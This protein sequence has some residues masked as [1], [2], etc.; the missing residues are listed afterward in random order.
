MEVKQIVIGGNILSLKDEQAR[1]LAATLQAALDTLNGKVPTQASSSNQLADK[2]FV[3]SSIDTA[4][5]TFRGTF[6]SDTE[7][8]KASGDANDYAFLKSTDANGNISY[9]RYKYVEGSGWT[10]EYTL[11]NSSFTAAQW[12]TI[13]S[14]MT[15]ALV[16]KLNGIEAGAQKNAA[17]TVVDASYVHTDN[18]YTSTEKTKLANIEA[19]A[20]KNDPNTVIDPDYVHIDNNYTDA[21]KAKLGGIEAGAQK[22]AA[23]TVVDSKYVHTDNNYTNEDKAKLASVS[24]PTYD[25]Q[26]ESLTFYNI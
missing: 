4:T 21:E 13:N 2:A 19:G 15:A 24:A 14:G 7:L 9:T 10:E 25:A 26:D 11:N 1:T 3:N 18:N 5:A 6:E 22:N 12:A 17:G 16:T 8:K 20:Q 23:G